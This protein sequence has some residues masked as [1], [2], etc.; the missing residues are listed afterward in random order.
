[1]IKT[2]DYLYCHTTFRDESGEI[3]FTKGQSYEIVKITFEGKVALRDNQTRIHIMGK[4]DGT[5]DS[6]NYKNDNISYETWFSMR[7]HKLKQLLGD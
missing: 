1:M 2:G 5:I 6:I 3:S 4:L 7:E